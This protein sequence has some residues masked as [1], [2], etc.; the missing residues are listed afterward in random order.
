[1]AKHKPTKMSLAPRGQATAGGA[2]PLAHA[3]FD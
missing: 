2:T 3:D 1:M